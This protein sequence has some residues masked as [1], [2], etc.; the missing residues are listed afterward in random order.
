MIWE[1]GKVGELLEGLEEGGW[2]SRLFWFGG[3]ACMAL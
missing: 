1:G 3:E 2:G